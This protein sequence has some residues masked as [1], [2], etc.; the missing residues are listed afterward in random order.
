MKHQAFSPRAAAAA[1]V[2][3]V[4]LVGGTATGAIAASP[5]PSPSPSAPAPAPAPDSAPVS[6]PAPAAQQDGQTVPGTITGLTATPGDGSAVLSWSAPSSDGGSPVLEYVVRG[7]TSPGSDDIWNHVPGPSTTISGLTNGTTYYF[8]V[9]AV[10]NT[11]GDGADSASVRVTPFAGT[12]P[13]AA[14]SRPGAPTGLKVNPGDS[15]LGLSWSAPAGSSPVSGYHVYLGENSS[16][17]AGASEFTTTGTSFQL[18]SADNGSVYF[19]KVTAF[20]AAGEGPGTPETSVE[21]GPRPVTPQ[22]VPTP[23]APPRPTGLTARARHG[24]VILSW[25]PPKGGLK[26]T[27]GYNIYMGTSPG[28]EGATPSVP[29]LIPVTSYTIAPLRDGTRYYFQV[30][31]ISFSG[32]GARVSARSAEV[33]AVPGTGSGTSSGSGSGAGSAPTVGSQ[34]E[35]IATVP[36]PAGVTLPPVQTAQ[37]QNS[38]GL[39]TGLVAALVALAAL[40]VGGGAAALMLLRRRRYDRRYGVG[41]APRHPHD[42]AGEYRQPEEMHGPRDR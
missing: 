27:E 18:T 19:I 6:A 10:N 17:L 2:L 12:A 13:P 41:P 4:V 7:G 34:T 1:A 39:S 15:Y 36:P 31:L 21:V 20:N 24:E 32:S 30:T 29:Y 23:A 16:S 5:S 28:H 22:A 33:S 35:P 9:F 11:G 8:R 3:T 37:D 38:A 14:G 40:V 26:S 42:A 25:S